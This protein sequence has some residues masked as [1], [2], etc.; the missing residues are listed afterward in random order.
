MNRCAEFAKNE[1]EQ[2]KLEW[3]DLMYFVKR[4]VRFPW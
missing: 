4:L 2:M 3:K 1:L